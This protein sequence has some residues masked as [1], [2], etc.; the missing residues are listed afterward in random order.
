MSPATRGCG[1]AGIATL[2]FSAAKVQT[3][4][5]NIR[6]SRNGRIVIIFA[7][8]TDACIKAFPYKST[9]QD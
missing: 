9:L 4:T 7:A 3:P 1:F 5:K 2:T 8:H 6:A